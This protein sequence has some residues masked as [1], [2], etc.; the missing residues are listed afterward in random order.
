[1]KQQEDRKRVLFICTGNTCRSP[2]AKVILEQKLKT[3]GEIEKFEVDSAAYDGSSD[4]SA[5]PNARKVIEKRFGNDLLV[6]HRS[7]ELT[8]D[9]IERQDVI[10][11]MEGWMKEG[12]PQ[13][14]TWT[15]HEY[16]GG[17]GDI[18]DPYS[19]SI[20]PYIDCAKEIS[21]VLDKVLNKLVLLAAEKTFVNKFSKGGL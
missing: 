19:D 9:L 13:E 2:M 20:E 7:K 4:K 11:V 14:K 18:D 17:S 8:P 12:L 10:L 16:A 1:M 3:I 6:S 21:D 5:H 15:L